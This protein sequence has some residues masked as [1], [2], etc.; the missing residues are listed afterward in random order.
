MGNGIY[1]KSGKRIGTLYGSSYSGGTGGSLPPTPLSEVAKSIGKALVVLLLVFGIG[2]LSV[3]TYSYL[4]YHESDWTQ[5]DYDT[6]KWMVLASLASILVGACGAALWK[7]ESNK[8]PGTEASRLRQR[9]NR[10]RWS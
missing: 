6:A 3:L 9:S 8:L 5:A 4:Q 7:K 1:N 10:S 2:L